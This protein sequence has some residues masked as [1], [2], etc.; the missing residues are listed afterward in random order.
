L[1]DLGLD[2]APRII[3]ERVEAPTEREGG[4]IVKSVDELLEKLRNE[5]K[6]L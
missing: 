5:A 3:V 6:V 4:V 1:E 2:V